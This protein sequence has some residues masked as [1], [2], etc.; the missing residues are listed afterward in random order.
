MGIDLRNSH[1]ATRDLRDWFPEQSWA[2]VRQAW[3]ISEGD[4]LFS[5]ETVLGGSGIRSSPE[6]HE[7]LR[8]FL[9]RPVISLEIVDPRFFHSGHSTGRTRS[10]RGHVLPRGVLIG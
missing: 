2:T 10:R 7:E 8:Q 3:N 5:G 4:F 9:G 1:H 6:R